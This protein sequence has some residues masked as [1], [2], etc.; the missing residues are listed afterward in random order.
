MSAS[1][2]LEKKILDHCTG[3]TALSSPSGGLYMALLTVAPT[4]ADTG[5]TITEATYTGYARKLIAPADMS[6]AAGASPAEVHNAVQELFAA[7]TA[8][9]STVIGWALLDSATIGAGNVFFKGSMT[10]VVISTTQTPPT[11][12][13]SALSLTAD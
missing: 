10:S 8:G 3:K 4:D 6:A 11:L 9:T 1:D 7:C 12:P 5:A 13:A 2:Y